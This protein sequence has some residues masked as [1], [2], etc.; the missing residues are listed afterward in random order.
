[1]GYLEIGL[2]LLFF[3]AG[4]ICSNKKLP[5]NMLFS[6]NR[7]PLKNDDTWRES[8]RYSGKICII[9]GL[10]MILIG[11][12]VEYVFDGSFLIYKISG[13]IV[14]CMCIMACVMPYIHYYKVFDYNGNRKKKRY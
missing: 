14:F 5:R 2:G 11:V 3:I 1:M 8:N 9:Y 13:T 7:Y 10:L 6:K 4:L 12:L